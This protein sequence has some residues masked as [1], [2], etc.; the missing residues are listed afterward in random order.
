MLVA[1]GVWSLEFGVWMSV[2]SLEFGV[3]SLDKRVVGLQAAVTS[4]A[5][6]SKVWIM[7][8]IMDWSTRPKAAVDWIMDWITLTKFG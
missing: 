6:L 2:W 7:D 1:S 8:W 3:W 4:C 5:P